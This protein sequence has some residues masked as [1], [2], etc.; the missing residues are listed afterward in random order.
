MRPTLIQRAGFPDTYRSLLNDGYYFDTSVASVLCGHIRRWVDTNGRTW[1]VRP[2]ILHRGKRTDA[3]IGAVVI[4]TH[5]L[6][7]DASAGG[8][9][10]RTHLPVRPYI[11]HRGNILHRGKRTNAGN[12]IPDSRTCPYPDTPKKSDGITTTRRSSVALSKE[13][14]TCFH[15]SLFS[16]IIPH[17]RIPAG[18]GYAISVQNYLPACSSFSVIVHWSHTSDGPKYWIGPG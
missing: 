10:S 11:L 7:V 15:S 2:Y 18:M 14:K 1:P 17:S 4:P 9:A 13:H 12:V 5:P 16:I 8:L 6:F 3:G